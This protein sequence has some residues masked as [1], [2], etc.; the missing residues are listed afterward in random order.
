MAK[1]KKQ[2]WMPLNEAITDFTEINGSHYNTRVPNFSL[3]PTRKFVK[4]AESKITAKLMSQYNMNG[5]YIPITTYGKATCDPDNTYTKGYGIDLAFRKASEAMERQCKKLLIAYSK[6][7]MLKEP[8]PHTTHKSYFIN[9]KCSKPFDFTNLKM[10]IPKGQ[11]NNA[12]RERVKIYKHNRVSQK[13][14]FELLKV[15]NEVLC[16]NPLP[17]KEVE[18]IIDSVYYEPKHERGKHGK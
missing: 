13:Y 16:A 8:K 4:F 9:K 12:L 17:A 10:T 6:D 18:A 5:K 14:A 1:T 7:H 11:R 2:E 3:L 15:C